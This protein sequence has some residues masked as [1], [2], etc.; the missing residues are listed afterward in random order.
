MILCFFCFQAFRAGA[1]AVPV[2]RAAFLVS[3]FFSSNVAWIR[4]GSAFGQMRCSHPDGEDGNTLVASWVGCRR[5]FST[6]GDM[7]GALGSVLRAAFHGVEISSGLEATPFTFT[8]C[9]YSSCIIATFIAQCII[10]LP[11]GYLPMTA[12][13]SIAQIPHQFC[14]N[15]NLGN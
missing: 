11:L 8:R 4:C 7:N 1:Q 10:S 5:F 13:N 15:T 3:L 9:A 14:D 12:P 6:N 2:G